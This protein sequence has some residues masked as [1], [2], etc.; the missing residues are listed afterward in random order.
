MSIGKHPIGFLSIS[1]V[2][3]LVSSLVGA[4]YVLNH[5]RA[6]E[7][8]IATSEFVTTEASVVISGEFSVEGGVRLLSPLL[9]GRI[10]KVFKEDGDEVK[11]AGE[12]LLELDKGP[13][14]CKVREAEAAL[15][16]A[17]IGVNQA[18]KAP[19]AQKTKISQV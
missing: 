9:P 8:P 5:G 15:K 14:E 10:T 13:A 2:L 12:P 17:N 7:Q 4:N 1:G 6:S 18:A 11:E 19:L 3:L 16:R